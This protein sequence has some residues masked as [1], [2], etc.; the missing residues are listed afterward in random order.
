MTLHIGETPSNVQMLAAS[1]IDL[2]AESAVSNPG[3]SRCRTGKLNRLIEAH[4]TSIR[5]RDFAADEFEAANSRYDKKRSERQYFRITPDG[6]P[7]VMLEMH[8]FTPAQVRGSIEKH[9]TNLAN[10]LGYLPEQSQAKMLSEVYGWKAD[11]IERLEAYY[12]WCDDISVECGRADAAQRH[13]DLE[14][15]ADKALEQILA[16]QVSGASE[17]RKKGDYLRTTSWFNDLENGFIYTET[18]EAMMQGM[19]CGVAS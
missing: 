19:G 13:D 11:A 14:V 7:K 10:R 9:Y 1:T 2:A 16:Y 18:V 8:L 3:H 4:K 17:G 12:N 6:S 15:K 5:E